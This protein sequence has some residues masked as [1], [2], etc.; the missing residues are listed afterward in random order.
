[1]NSIEDL[2]SQ[3]GCCKTDLDRLK[4]I[5]KIYYLEFERYRENRDDVLEILEGLLVWTIQLRWNAQNNDKE[6]AS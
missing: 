1:M 6:D 2:Y 4:L 3:L 5:D